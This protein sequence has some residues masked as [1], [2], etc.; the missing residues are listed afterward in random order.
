MAAAG[1]GGWS[2]EGRGGG[3]P[4]AGIRVNEGPVR[5]RFVFRVRPVV[6]VLVWGGGGGGSLCVG[7]RSYA[8]QQRLT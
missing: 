2:E 3:I 4:D 1:S 6:S 8:R 5:G 7:V